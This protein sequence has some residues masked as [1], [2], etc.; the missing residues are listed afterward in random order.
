MLFMLLSP[1]FQGAV[2]V[3]ATLDIIFST[4]FPRH[5]KAN[6]GME[7]PSHNLRG[8]FIAWPNFLDGVFNNA[9]KLQ[10]GEIIIYNTKCKSEIHWGKQS[11]N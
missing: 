5:A 9:C 10:I 3:D 8:F 1:K 4:F 2:H 6:L 7:W 11:E